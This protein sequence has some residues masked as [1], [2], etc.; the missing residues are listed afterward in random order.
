ML[1]YVNE[2]NLLTHG[3]ISNRSLNQNKRFVQHKAAHSV[4]YLR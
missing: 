4:K 3:L 2:L 1:K